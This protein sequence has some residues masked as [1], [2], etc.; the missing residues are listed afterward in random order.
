MLDAQQG[1]EHGVGRLIAKLFE[2]EIVKAVNGKLPGRKSYDE[3]CAKL[4]AE[5]IQQQLRKSHQNE[6]ETTGCTFRGLKV[7]I[8]DG[9]KISIPSTQATSAS[10]IEQKGERDQCPRGQNQSPSTNS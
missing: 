8:P 10:S 5:I 6:Y 2:L 4:P 3:A 1:F 9:T 7:L